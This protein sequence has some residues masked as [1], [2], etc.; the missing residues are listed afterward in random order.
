MAERVQALA[1][2]GR[3]GSGK[4]QVAAAL[5]RAAR[6]LGWRV[7]ALKHDGHAAEGDDWEKPGSDTRRLA[8][9]GASWTVVA[10]GGQ[11][12]WRLTDD[13]AA[14]DAVALCQRLAAWAGE[15]GGE[16][17]LVVVEG[18]QRSLLPKVAVL[19]SPEDCA[20]LQA[21][22][23]ARV[24]AGVGPARADW[25]AGVQWPVYDEED[26][27]RLCQDGQRAGWWGVAGGGQRPAW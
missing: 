7:A 15:L 21:A 3:Q 24:V 18:Y 23:L 5:V 6:T 9:A 27:L 20:W 14:D 26:I 19:R 16:L 2:V 10:G 25:L 11:S 22:G 1:V 12:L 17:D 4:T 8:A 13:A